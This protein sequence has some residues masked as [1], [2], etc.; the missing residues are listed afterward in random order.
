MPEVTVEQLAVMS[1]LLGS[2]PIVLGEMHDLP[3]AREAVRQ[4]MRAE[5]VHYL[6]LE[7]PIA[8]PNL[9]EADGRIKGFGNDVANY[10]TGIQL[11]PNS[12]TLRQLVDKA[13]KR[14]IPVYFHDVPLARSRLNGV[15]DGRNLNA[16]PAY[17]SQF[18]IGDK[19]T[20]L[21][22]SDRKAATFY[23]QRNAYAANYLQTQLGKGVKILRGLVVLAG[24]DHLVPDR[25]LNPLSTLQGCLGIS[26][27]RAF[28]VD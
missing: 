1:E 15:N 7:S 27:D 10:F 25:G 19:M 14:G 11:Y 24:S 26:N 12:F 28:I 21:P 17:A 5:F 6:S 22:T 13:T 9:A 3:H 4:L 20:A 18:L 2:G 8:P 16:Y 23:R